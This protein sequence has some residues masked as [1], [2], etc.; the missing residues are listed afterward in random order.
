ML[1]TLQS[2]V[3]RNLPHSINNF[4]VLNFSG[5]FRLNIFRLRPNAEGTQIGFV[6]Q[7]EMYRVENCQ[8]SKISGM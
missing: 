3:V 6:E 7:K 2:N 4:I 8:V 5:S 1:T